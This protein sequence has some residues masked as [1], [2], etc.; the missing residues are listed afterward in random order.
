MSASPT[1][2][3]SVTIC[4]DFSAAEF[5]EDRQSIMDLNEGI[6]PE[7]AAPSLAKAWKI[8][9]EREK[10]QWQQ[11]MEAEAANSTEAARV[12]QEMEEHRVAAECEEQEAAKK[13]DR[14][15]NRVRHLPI[16]V[17]VA[18]P[19]H[20][21]TAIGPATYQAM[22]KMEYVGIHPFTDRGIDKTVA[23][24]GFLTSK[25]LT[26]TQD[27]DGNMVFVPA[28]DLWESSNVKDEDLTWEEYSVGS[29]QMV[30]V[31]EAN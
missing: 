16:Q 23:P 5:Q 26:M 4:P 11:R 1:T 22:K 25:T 28:H 7:Q 31:M 30:A 17:G 29:L 15:K 10:Q 20:P 14:H 21:R 18:L 24:V 27:E 12:A 6:T 3:P 19:E 13:E 9:N 8:Q 2:D